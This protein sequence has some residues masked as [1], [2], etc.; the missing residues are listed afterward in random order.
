MRRRC[1]LEGQLF[2]CKWFSLCVS[3]VSS[4]CMCE[5]MNEAIACLSL[6]MTVCLHDWACVHIDLRGERWKDRRRG[7]S[8]SGHDV[9]IWDRAHRILESPCEYTRDKLS[10]LLDKFLCPPRFWKT[11]IDEKSKLAYLFSIF[12]LSNLILLV[13]LFLFAGQSLSGLWTSVICYQTRPCQDLVRPTGHGPFGTCAYLHW[14]P[15]P[16]S[17]PTA[18][19]AQQLS[20][21]QCTEQQCA[22]SCPDPQAQLLFS[23]NMYK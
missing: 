5:C 17:S 11:F 13:V 10:F 15:C 12:L 20:A 18:A 23:T 16:P 19:K 4:A 21:E 9:Q 2:P 1:T 14:A 22:D 8:R 7:V 3:F 6:S